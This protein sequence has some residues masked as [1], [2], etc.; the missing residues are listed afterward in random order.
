MIGRPP[1]STLFPYTTLFRSPCLSVLVEPRDD[2]HLDLPSLRRRPRLFAGRAGRA[3]RGAARA[4]AKKAAAKGRRIKA[5]PGAPPAD[6]LRATDRT[7]TRIR[8]PG[9]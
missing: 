5:P 2:R 4:A 9:R 6:T 7:E 1:R 8:R 3:G